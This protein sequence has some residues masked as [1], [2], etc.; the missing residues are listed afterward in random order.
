MENFEKYLTEK[1]KL[2]EFFDKLEIQ[3]NACEEDFERVSIDKLSDILDLIVENE[4]YAFMIG[5][6]I[7]KDYVKFQNKFKRYITDFEEVKRFTLETTL[8][9]FLNEIQLLRKDLAA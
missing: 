2:Q 8:E 6:K 5:K 7:Y 4:A 1:Q 9:D 3:L